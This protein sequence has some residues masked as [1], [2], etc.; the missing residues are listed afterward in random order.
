MVSTPGRAKGPILYLDTIND[1]VATRLRAP[2]AL[3]NFEGQLLA[4]FSPKLKNILPI[5]LGLSVKS[6]IRSR[7][8]VWCD[9]RYIFIQAEP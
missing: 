6:H 2:S 3:G 9:A 4:A 1:E 7:P 5:R 8:F